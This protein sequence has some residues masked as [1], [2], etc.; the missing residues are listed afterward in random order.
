M[1][2][3]HQRQILETVQT[4]YEVLNE[5]DRQLEPRIASG[6]V[7]ECS[8]FTNEI[9]KYIDN[10]TGKETLTGN[11]LAEYIELLDK[12]KRGEITKGNL[13]NHVVKIENSVKSELKPDKLEVVF[14]PYNA[15]MWDS[16]ESIWLAAKEDP[17]CDAYC[18][19]IPYFEINPDRT[20]GKM[21]Y[22]GAN[23]YCYNVEITNW[24]TYDIATRHPDVI[25]I[26]Y[27]YDDN[28]RNA[29]IHPNYYSKELKKH[30][31]CLIY[32]PYFVAPGNKVEEYCAYLPG[33]LNA[34]YVMLQS[35]E[36]R[37]SYISYY[38]KFDRANNL[39]SYFGRA[40]DKFIAIGSPKYDKV[41]NSKS[42][43]Y[44]IPPEWWRLI[45]KENGEKKKVILYNT[46]MF[47]WINGGE[48]YFK[49][50]SSVFEAFR[51]RRD[52]V[53][54][55]RPHPN[56]ELN[57]RTLRPDLLSEYLKVVET[58]KR[59]AWGIYDDTPDLHRAIA[60]CDAYYGDGSSVIEL[61]KVVGKPIYFQNTDFTDENPIELLEHF[62]FHIKDIFEVCNELYVVSA[63]EYIFKLVGN[64]LKYES[65]IKIDPAVL[66]NRNF[67]TQLVIDDRIIFIPHNYNKIVVYNVK[68]KDYNEYP[69]ELKDE[70]IA[71]YNEL[72][73]NFF[74][75]IIYKNK[76]FLV[77]CGYRNIVAFNIDTKETKHC[78]DL[79]RLFPK[80][81]MISLFYGW[82][83][84]NENTILLASLYTNE[85]LEF[86]LDTY[87]YKVHRLGNK[88][89][90]FQNIFKHGDVFFL[91]GKQGFM[92]KW[93]Y[94]TGEVI[95]YDKLP[96]DFK[97]SKKQDRVF[98]AS[99]IKPYN[100][101]LIL[102][103]GFTNMVL[104]F[105]FDTCEFRK[106]DEFDAILSRK[107]KF[108]KY[109]NYSFSTCN[110]IVDKYLYFAHKNDVL[111]RYDFETQAIEEICDIKP[112][113]TTDIC[114]MLNNSF[115]ERMLKGV[116]SDVNVYDIDKLQ[117]G[118]AGNRIYNFVKDRVLKK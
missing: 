1:R 78:L 81:E 105:N 6:L 85:V 60:W 12:Y 38:K 58:Y 95:T 52:V 102:F 2:P 29:T 91:V 24:L 69:L 82:T 43:N 71:P 10:L 88:N 94:E 70:F 46:H 19:P 33:V 113:L 31:E 86:N 9:K 25:F 90:S 72:N 21:H 28:V 99:N 57:F 4:L 7:S 5:L 51:N 77:P 8:E 83:W 49:R 36:I 93:N 112:D 50:I 92:M 96:K 100:N 63:N 108:E 80:G 73:R 74:N 16:L 26:H 84:L 66:R 20:L 37:Q 11:L 111:Y 109:D 48:T 40:E 68:T 34:D 13:H 101:K 14:L 116:T 44:E 89:Q 62:R 55:W 117:D 54:W 114:N 45:Y 30:C 41:I 106:L 104:E 76:I 64:S 98:L 87:E 61:F 23:F 18:V 56:T 42:I 107:P 110:F 118:Q 47:R 15:S 59:E 115:I 79:L 97:A 17:K 3:Y 32:V 103:G 22:E 35:E 39:N 75:G 53:L 27:A 65:E 67:F